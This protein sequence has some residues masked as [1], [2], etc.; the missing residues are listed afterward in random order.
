MV[1]CLRREAVGARSVVLPEVLDG[2][3]DFMD[4]EAVC[5]TLPPLGVIEDFGEVFG[6]VLGVQVHSV[7]GGAV[8]VEE[9]VLGGLEHCGGVVGEGA[10]L[11]LENSDGALAGVGH[12]VFEVEYG[13][14]GD[15]VARISLMFLGDWLLS[16]GVPLLHVYLD[17]GYL[18]S[19]VLYEVAGLWAVCV[20]EV[21]QVLLRNAKGMEHMCQGCRCLV[22][23][24]LG[25]LLEAAGNGGRAHGSEQVGGVLFDA[26]R[27]V[28]CLVVLGT[29]LPVVHSGHFQG[30]RQALVRILRGDGGRLGMVRRRWKGLW[31]VGPSGSGP[32]RAS[33]W[34]TVVGSL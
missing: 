21:L 31:P 11:V 25:L 2:S 32:Y 14:V 20:E 17:V 23:L 8:V 10:V 22:V 15:F 13:L 4:G 7:F 27:A 26:P 3:P 28:D 19:A 6:F 12:G 29:G 24:S 9:A 1:V 18:L 16:V 34:M 30:G 33:V 5:F